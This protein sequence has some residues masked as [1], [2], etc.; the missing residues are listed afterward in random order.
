MIDPEATAA[1]DAR[2]AEL[3]A[4]LR[5]ILEGTYVGRGDR[6]V[7]TKSRWGHYEARLYH[8]ARAALANPAST[9]Q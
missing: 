1:K 4:A 3:E 7:S 9:E 6:P 5:N 8:A 2:I